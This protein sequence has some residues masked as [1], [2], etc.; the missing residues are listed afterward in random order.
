VTST[1][2]GDTPFLFAE[3]TCLRPA[4]SRRGLWHTCPGGRGHSVILLDLF[5]TKTTSEFQ[6]IFSVETT[7]I[8]SPKPIFDFERLVFVDAPAGGFSVSTQKCLLTTRRV[9]RCL[10]APLLRP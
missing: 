4:L 8:K 2:V 9:L 5:S 10:P 6:S 1:L 3:A 7:A